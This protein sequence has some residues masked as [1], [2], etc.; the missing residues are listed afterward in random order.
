M[1]NPSL[2][3]SNKLKVLDAVVAA[4]GSAPFTKVIERA[5]M[6]RGNLSYIADSLEELG[7]IERHRLWVNK[8][9]RT[10]L[11]ITDKGRSHLA[12]I[13]AALEVLAA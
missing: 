10:D 6:A 12:K 2:L 9:P 11:V 4:G 1:A 5:P 3:T 13:K 8:R 7:L